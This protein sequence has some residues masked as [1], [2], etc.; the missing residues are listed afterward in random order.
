MVLLGDSPN[1]LPF[2]ERDNKIICTDINARQ[3][4]YLQSKKYLMVN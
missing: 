3:K 2:D 1:R 4:A